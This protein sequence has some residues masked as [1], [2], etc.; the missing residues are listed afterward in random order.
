M[1]L[2]MQ[3]PI[4]WALKKARDLAC[5]EADTTAMERECLA[6]SFDNTAVM[7]ALVN[8]VKIHFEDPYLIAARQLAVDCYKEAGSPCLGALA[9][10]YLNGTKD[11]SLEVR[12]AYRA[13]LHLERLPT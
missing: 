6:G 10:D 2:T 13:L 8:L 5:N 3:K 9:S 7:S 4:P 12:V 11:S 1:R